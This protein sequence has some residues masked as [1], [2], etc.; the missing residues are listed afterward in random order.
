MTR[1][2][3]LVVD[4][5]L[6]LAE[7]LAEGLADRGFD[8]VALRVGEKRRRAWLEGDGFDAA[9][10]DLRMPEVDGLALLARSRK[11]YP[12]RPVIR[13]DGVRRH[14]DGGPGH[15]PGGLPLS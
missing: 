8:A 3:V 9:V 7:T 5:P 14:R 15:P 4:D 1:P 11:A 12:E 10:T 6:D 2:R 13:D